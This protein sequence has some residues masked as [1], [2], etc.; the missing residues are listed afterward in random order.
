MTQVLMNLVAAIR[1]ALRAM[2]TKILQKIINSTGL[3]RE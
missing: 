2:E 3:D 1:L